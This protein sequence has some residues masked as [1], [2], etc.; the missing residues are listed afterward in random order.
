MKPIGNFAGDAW[1]AAPTTNT[2]A[3]LE[4]GS[5][6]GSLVAVGLE[7]GADGPIA[8]DGVRKKSWRS[9]PQRL[10]WKWFNC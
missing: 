2:L 9:Q 4:Y 5:G 8:D 10:F 3:Y 1:N 6:T 7:P